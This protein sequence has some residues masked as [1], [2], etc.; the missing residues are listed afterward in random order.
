MC[1]RPGRRTLQRGTHLAEVEEV[2]VDDLDATILGYVRALVIHVGQCP[3]LMAASQQ[4]I[5]WDRTE[6]GV[7]SGVPLHAGQG[8]ETDSPI[9][10]RRALRCM[11]F[12]PRDSS[13]SRLAAF[14]S[15][16]RASS[17]VP[18]EVRA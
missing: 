15:S 12:S 7:D 9:R 6:G 14:S 18:I 3:D 16:N 8:W 17:D 4:F 13:D 2:S 1:I 10:N 11:S 5:D